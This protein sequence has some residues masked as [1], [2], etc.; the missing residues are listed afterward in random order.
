VLLL[1]ALGIGSA[2]AVLADARILKHW[3]ASRTPRPSWPARWADGDLSARIDVKSGDATS[4][5][6]Q[7]RDMQAS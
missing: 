3:A 6:A 5:M 2:A 4:L 1:A 7:L